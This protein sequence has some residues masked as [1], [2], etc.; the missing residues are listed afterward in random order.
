MS[1][2][3]YSFDRS[4][5]ANSNKDPGKFLIAGIDEAGRG[6]WAGPV[7]ACAM[8]LP[9]DF[10]DLRIND[11]KQLSPALRETL[12]KKITEGSFWAIGTGQV[13]LIDS[14]NILQ[15]TYCAMRNALQ[16]L[17]RANPQI[18]PDLVLVDG[19]KVPGIGLPQKAVIRGDA[20]SAS[21]A[22]ASIVAKVFRDRMMRVLDRL[23]PQYGFA[24]H[25]GYGTKLHL[26]NLL[27]FGPSPVHRKSF[28]P[29]RS[30]LIR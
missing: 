1:E 27:E 7:V 15:A 10:H 9:K 13:S 19:R 5:A 24:R 17:L 20:Q 6:P 11:S 30:V 28:A 22:A 26:K 25:K 18:S 4:L 8:I 23:Y 29:V 21:I 3:L 12:Y 16:N 2:S 14:D